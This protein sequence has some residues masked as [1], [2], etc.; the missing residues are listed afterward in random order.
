MDLKSVLLENKDI[1][2]VIATRSGHYCI[3]AKV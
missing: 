1:N 3:F 2:Q